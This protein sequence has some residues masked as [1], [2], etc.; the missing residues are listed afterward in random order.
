MAMTDNIKEK[1]VAFL[2][3]AAMGVGGAMLTSWRTVATLEAS[4]QDAKAEINL[5]KSRDED[6][7][8]EIQRMYELGGKLDGVIR[9]L[10]ALR[11][12]IRAAR[13]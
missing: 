7:R 12:D 13:K 9:E 11:D 1:A 3:S 2:L 6:H 5:L 10:Q 8:K 4:L